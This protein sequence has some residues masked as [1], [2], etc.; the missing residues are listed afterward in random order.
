MLA[1]PAV[2]EGLR[3]ALGTSRLALAILFGSRATGNARADSDFD[4]GILPTFDMTLGDELALASALSA[5]TGTEVDVVRLDVDNPLLGNEVARTG[6]CLWEAAPG[7]F[8]AYRARAVSAWI[9]FDEL[10]APHRTHLL[11]RLAGQ[12]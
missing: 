7:A 1:T 9:A 10:V 8:A 2:I 11:M 12:R 3:A 5:V 6:V 4:I